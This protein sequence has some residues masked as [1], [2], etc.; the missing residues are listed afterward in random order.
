MQIQWNKV[1]WYSNLV[2][3]ILFIAI[4]ALGFYLG[5]QYREARDAPVIPEGYIPPTEPP[6]A[7]SAE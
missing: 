3:V 5:D 2:A 7:E 4:F 1:T 6:P